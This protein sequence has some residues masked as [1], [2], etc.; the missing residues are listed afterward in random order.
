MDSRYRPWL[1]SQDSSID[2]VLGKEGPVEPICS[3]SNEFDCRNLRCDPCL[4]P[5]TNIR[6]LVV[7]GDNGGPLYWATSSGD[8]VDLESA[9]GQS[10]LFF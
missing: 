4:Q 2:L 10:A 6:D 3:S 7:K 5:E 1:I 8:G 9:I